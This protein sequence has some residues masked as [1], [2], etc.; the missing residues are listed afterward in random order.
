MHAGKAKQHEAKMKNE[1]HSKESDAQRRENE[2]K[3]KSERF[4]TQQR[5]RL[6]EAK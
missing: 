1:M 3:K 4:D 2:N 5:V 6:R